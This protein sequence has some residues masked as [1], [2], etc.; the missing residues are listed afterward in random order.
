MCART[1]ERRPRQ[2]RPSSPRRPEQE[3]PMTPWPCS[4][5]PTHWMPSSA[6]CAAWAY[7]GGGGGLGLFDPRVL[8]GAGQVAAARAEVAIGRVRLLRAVSRARR[9]VVVTASVDIRGRARLTRFVVPPPGTTRP[10]ALPVL[11]GLAR[12][13]ATEPATSKA[14]RLGAA[15][16]LA[17]DG[18]EPSRWW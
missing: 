10:P 2:W 8:D 16:W 6:P 1:P 7:P 17:R 14:Q 11:R 18:A 15:L 13:V 5:G 9:R 12:A 4:G 3:L